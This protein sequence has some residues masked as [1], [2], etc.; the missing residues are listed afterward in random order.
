MEANHRERLWF[1]ATLVLSSVSIT[2]IVFGIW[3]LVE[4]RFFRE[5]N[6]LTLH[7]LYITRGIASSLLL[8]LWASWYVLHQRQKTEAELRRSRERYR[9]LLE[10]SPGAVALY[11]ASL[12]VSEWNETAERLYGFTKDEVIGHVLPTVPCEKQGELAEFLRRVEAG[13][14]ILDVETLRRDKS[15][16]A[17]EVQLS[18]LPFQESPGQRYFLEV[19]SDIRERVQMRTRLLEI[20]KLTSMGKMAAGTAHH[21]NTPLAAMLLRV[22]MMREHLHHDPCSADLEKLEAGLRFCQ[23]FVQ[24]LLEFSRRPSAQKRPERVAALVQSVISFLAP[25]IQAKRAQMVLELESAEGE[26]VLADRNQ[27][28][29]LFSVLLSNA[30]DAISPGGTITIQGCCLSPQELELRI[31]DNGCGISGTDF[32]HVL[33]PFFTTKESG[34][35]TGLGLAIAQNIVKEHGGTILLESKPGQGTVACMRFP[36]SCRAPSGTGG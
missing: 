7:Y 8:A 15:G 31:A 4:G 33:E 26:Q 32:P 16:A 3:E 35:G 23:Q 19:T 21:L 25:S 6:Y 18:L 17:F 36:V 29:V 22:Q 2:A 5:A 24:R 13:H 20:E 27:L 30:L 28:E 12:Q 9:G 1:W 11:D 14:R 10:V 34:K